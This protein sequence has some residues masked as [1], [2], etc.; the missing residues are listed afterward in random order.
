MDC[1]TVK[2]PQHR[3]PRPPQRRPT[4]SLLVFGAKQQPVERDALTEAL[5]RILDGKRRG[6][7]LPL[8]ADMRSAWS[9]LQAR[10]KSDI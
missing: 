3:G 8:G 7:P 2:R 10:E 4:A 6:T 5:G 1:V 9:D